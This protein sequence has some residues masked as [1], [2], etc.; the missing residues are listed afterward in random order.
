[1]NFREKGC[2]GGCQPPVGPM[3]PKYQVPKPPMAETV[4][5]KPVH[6]IPGIGTMPPLPGTE[7]L[8]SPP[9]I[10]PTPPTAVLN[11]FPADEGFL[12][13]TMFRGIYRPYK[14][15]QSR[16]VIPADEKATM[17]LDVDKYAFAAHDIQLYLDNYPNDQ[18][19]INLFNQ[20]VDG[21]VQAKNA[22]EEKF[23]ALTIESDALTTTP[24]NWTVGGWPW[25]GGM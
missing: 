1:M 3:M 5:G 16:M 12:K 9:K 18:E 6:P 22:Y 13:G 2:P 17:M 15:Y 25:A 10:G 21:Y 4:P 19:A 24:F 11:V 14:N 7:P 20:Y 8:P 23:G